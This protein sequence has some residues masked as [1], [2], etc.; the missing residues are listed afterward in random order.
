MR[1]A[2]LIIFGIFFLQFKCKFVMVDGLDVS[3]IDVS[4]WNS[5]TTKDSIKFSTTWGLMH[6]LFLES[7]DTIDSREQL[8]TVISR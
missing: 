1:V 3:R 2:D 4:E 7:F 8:P 5:V 6:Q